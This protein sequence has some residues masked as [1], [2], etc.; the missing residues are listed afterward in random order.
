M[1]KST[2]PNTGVWSLMTSLINAMYT[3]LYEEPQFGVYDYND[4]TTQTTPLAV[5][6]TNTY[7]YIPN[8]ALGPYSITSGGDFVLP[9]IQPWDASSGEFTWAGLTL[10]DTV[11]I[12]LDLYVTTTVP[13]QSIDVDLEVAIG[14][15]S[16]YDL[17]FSQNTFKTAKEN[18][19]NRFTSLYMGNLD[20]LNNPAKFKIRSDGAC[21]VKVNGW[22]LRVAPRI[23]KFL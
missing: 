4:L 20:T 23:R 15:G 5:P 22:Y 9:G 7:V 18:P 2:V 12:R 6:G 8:D 17:L 3:E 11:D 14:S 19:V 16:Q 10:G 1:A 13:N 21:T